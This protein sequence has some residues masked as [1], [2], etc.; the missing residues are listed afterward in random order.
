MKITKRQLRRIIRESLLLETEIIPII[1]N[2]YEDVTD[3]NILANY[4]HRND[5]LGALKVPELQYYIDKIEAL[6]LVDDSKGWLH[7]VGDEKQ[8]GPEPEGW[9]LDAVYA[10]IEDF[11]DEAFKVFSQKE[12]GVHANLPNKVEREIIGNALTQTYVMPKEIEDIEF[13]VRRKGGVPSNI[14]IENDYTV[15]NIRAADAEREGLTL[16]DIIRVLI[17]NG[18]K[19]RKKRR[20]IKH[21]PPVYD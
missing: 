9:D 10:F 12:K 14:N 6:Y 17:D 13:Q 21:T 16:D 4:A 8:M 15:S 7:L 3:I 20:P 18:A 19:E 5:R 11:E 2:S 1:T